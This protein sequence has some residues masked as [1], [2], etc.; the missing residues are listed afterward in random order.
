M[1][2]HI[3]NV[4]SN[5]TI[6][7]DDN[8]ILIYFNEPPLQAATTNQ[9]L[10]NT[11]NGVDDELTE[12]HYYRAIL[13]F[14]LAILLYFCL[15]CRVWKED[16]AGGK[17]EVIDKSLVK[18]VSTNSSYC[19]SHGTWFDSYCYLVPCREYYRTGNH[20]VLMKEMILSLIK[21][22]MNE[23]ESSAAIRKIQTW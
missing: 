20:S 19:V 15:V 1:L 7:M 3:S 11:G 10:N 5:K 21:G 16:V 18:K 17:P 12:I 13:A 14:L 9:T 2:K 23:Y 4:L 22:T 8:M 6:E